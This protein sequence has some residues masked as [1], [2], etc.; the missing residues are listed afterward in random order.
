[1]NK[2]FPLDDEH[3]ESSVVAQTRRVPSRFSLTQS[4]PKKLK[5]TTT[6]RSS[7]RVLRLYVP[8]NRRNREV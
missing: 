6:R 4:V 7:T 1:M 2:A 8:I 3:E 5:A